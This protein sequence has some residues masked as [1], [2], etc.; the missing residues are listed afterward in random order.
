MSVDRAKCTGASSVVGECL[1]PKYPIVE[2]PERM[3]HMGHFALCKTNV[4]TLQN[5]YNSSFSCL[6]TKNG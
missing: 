5:R 6:Y 3:L 1:V 2:H 4:F